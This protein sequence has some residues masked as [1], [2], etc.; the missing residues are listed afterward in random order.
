MKIIMIR[1]G[2]TKGNL[3]KRYVGRTDEGI[4]NAS[5]ETLK[6]IQKE[7]CQLFQEA[8]KVFV[9]PMLRC[10]ETADILF[11]EKRKIVIE[12]F[13]ECDF[14]IFEYCNY[15]E[16]NGNVDYQAYIDSNGEIGF[17]NGESKASFS[18]R[19]VDAF[20]SVLEQELRDIQQYASYVQN[21]K[22]IMVIVA[23]GGTIMSIL[24]AFSYPHK[25]YFDWYIDNGCGYMMEPERKDNTFL[26]KDIEAL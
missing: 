14:G 17:P 24:D 7:K 22:R 4:T 18:K 13:R 8:D 9:S 26:L 11:P 23:H 3:E 16:L 19:C 20:C 21:K 6:Q 1:H 5:R 15:Q 25:E 10:L 2:A 12:D